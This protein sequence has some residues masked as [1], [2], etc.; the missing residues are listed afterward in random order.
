LAQIQSNLQSLRTL[1][2]QSSNATYSASDRANLATQAQSILAEVDRTAQSSQFNGVNLLDGSF[3]Q[4]T[5]QIGAN[6]TANN[7]IVVAGLAS[8]RTSSLGAFNGV[9]LTNQSVSGTAGHLT[10]STGGS[11]PVSYTSA[12]VV[13]SDA[14]AVTAA[15]NNSGV[16]GLT[17]TANVNN[18]VG[19]NASSAAVTAGGT[20][21]ITINGLAINVNTAI[22]ASSADT[23]NQAAALQAINLQSATTGVTAT[24]NGSGLTLSSA[25]GG[26]ISVTVA[27]G[28]AT[29]A[30]QTSFGLGNVGGSTAVVTSG[31][32]NV[33]Y[34]A[35]T[36]VSGTLAI[37]GPGN[38]SQTIGQTGTALANID[39]STATGAQNAIASIDAAISSINN[40][41]STLGA[42]QN[43]FTSVVSTLQTESQNMSASRS[44][45]QDTNFASATANLTQEQI[46]QQAGTA[47]LAQANSLP[48]SVLTLLKGA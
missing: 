43:R 46:L 2:V 35:P 48:N 34:Q 23:T 16:A 17:A 45:I 37:G 14:S 4:Q 36:G 40:N 10:I 3:T 20:A 13:A 25:T 24:D 26:N 32:Y 8:A 21:I 47:M 5:F 41:R 28:T 39:L 38:T 9:S 31:T 27:A 15:I 11:S 18:A 1:A 42:V 19:S 6:A 29:G 12:G 7:Q 30:D 22:A 33:S 44:R